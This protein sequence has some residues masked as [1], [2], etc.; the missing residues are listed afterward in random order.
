MSRKNPIEKLAAEICWLGFVHPASKRGKT[1]ASYWK[2][3]PESTRQDYRCEARRFAYLLDRVNDDL[4]N[5]LHGWPA[6]TTAQRE[7]GDGG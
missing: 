6:V 1:K 5:E 4:L 3:L 2:S 7:R